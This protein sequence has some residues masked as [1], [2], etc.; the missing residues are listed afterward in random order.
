LSPT[1]AIAVPPDEVPS[2]PARIAVLTAG[3]G[4]A[5]IFV[6]KLAE[7]FPGL[8]V[9]QEQGEDA[10][11]IFRR[12]AKLRGWWNAMGQHLFTYY[13]L[14]V[15]S[16]LGK[17]RVNQL[18]ADHGLA[19]DLRPGIEVRHVP[20]VNS[21]ECH[22]HLRALQPQAVAVYGTRL[23]RPQTLAAIDAPFINYH[24]G[25]NPKYRGQSGAYW[26]LRQGDAEHA[27]LTI[28]LVDQGVDT[29]DVLYQARS[30]FTKADNFQT[31]HFAQMAQ[32]VPLMIKALEDALA[33]RLA[34]YKPDLPSQQFFMPTLWGYAWAGLTK[35]VW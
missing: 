16:R 11:A 7:R 18:C 19:R 2:S 12:R 20:S 5:N 4:L 17:S 29:G 25:M 30:S 15:V 28:H 27:G 23:L 22:A 31:Y 13:G 21:A 32:A 8:V 9:L 6:N 3:G 1:E 34:P 26:A 24:A 33:G 14:R 35:G 10:A